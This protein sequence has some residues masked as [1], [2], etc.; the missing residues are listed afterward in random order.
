MGDGV[1][2]CECCGGGAGEGVAEGGGLERG[3]R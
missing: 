2:G 1:G 3:V